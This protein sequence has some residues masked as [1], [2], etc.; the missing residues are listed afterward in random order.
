MEIF[1]VSQEL[2][3]FYNNQRVKNK[4]LKSNPQLGK[5]YRK[6]IDTLRMLKNMEEMYILNS[7]NYERLKGDLLG[8]SSVRIN[9]QYRL[10]FTEIEDT[11][12]LEI[13]V[14]AIEEISNHYQ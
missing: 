6:T 8:K 7:L 10:I 5:Q 4:H 9:Q 14:L 13:N 1:F 3:D 2:E 12:T 11:E